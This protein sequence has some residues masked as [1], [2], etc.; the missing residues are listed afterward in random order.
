MPSLR[1]KMLNWYIKRNFKRNSESDYKP[2]E[3]RRSM[4]QGARP[5]IPQSVTI[6][7]NHKIALGEWNIPPNPKADR[8]ILFLHGGGYVFGSPKTHRSLTARLAYE[9]RCKVFSLDYRLAPEYQCPIAIEDALTCYLWLLDAGYA[10]EQI[11][12]CGDSAGAG[13]CLALFQNLFQKGHPTPASITMYSPYVDL[14]LSGASI[15]DNAKSEVMFTRNAFERAV[16]D[17]S[18]K[19]DPSDSRVS[20]LWGNMTGLPPVQI[21]ASRSEALLDDAI[22]LDQRISDAGAHSKLI[23]EDGLVH[24]WPA[25]AG[26][27][28]EANRTISQTARFMKEHWPS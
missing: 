11:A 19:I 18:G 17:Y 28:P 15:D 13:L 23:L 9:A 8:V 7:P 2:S 20:P 6:E 4:E 21:F 10:P 25:F 24:A 22:R 27:L 14:T 5:R 1:A 12:L 26:Y 16:A 3:F